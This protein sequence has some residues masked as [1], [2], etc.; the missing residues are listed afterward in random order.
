MPYYAKTMRVVLYQTNGAD[1]RTST[2]ILGMVARIP[3]SNT[4]RHNTDV[5]DGK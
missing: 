3:I 2:I 1:K 5:L 4:R